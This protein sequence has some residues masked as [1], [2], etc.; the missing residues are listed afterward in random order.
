VKPALVSIVT[1][2]YNAAPWLAE[3]I[4]SVLAQTYQRWEYILLDNAS[5]DG[6]SEIARQF[7]AT[8]TRIRYVRNAELLN[9]VRNYNTALAMISPDSGYCKIVQADDWI[10]PDCV[11][12]M[13]DVFETSERVGLVGSYY[14]KD[15]AVR[16]YGLPYSRTPLP[17][18][19]VVRRL[20][21]DGLFLFGSPTAHMFRASIVRARQP[22]YAEHRY[23]EDTE[24]CVEILHEWDFGFVHQVLSFLRTGNESITSS[25]RSYG[26]KY[27][28]RYMTVRRY[29][30][31][32]F[33]PAQA[34]A[35][36]HDV[37]D[38]YYSFLAGCALRMRP[39]RLWRYHRKGLHMIGE[40]FDWAFL[41][42]RVVRKLSWWMVNPGLT[43]ANMFG[44]S[45][46]VDIPD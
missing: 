13:V 20:V 22:F 40:D 28:D 12:A 10:F 3:C 27:L 44:P 6:S 38:F 18:K 26:P 1:P 37:K 8:D 21:R 17:G 29:A 24:A 39:R 2:F 46:P 32:F 31:L 42:T 34:A 15:T 43:L 33:D 30:P 11:R 41:M 5:S 16:G 19:D 25:V 35:M 45:K 7:A 4:R 23:H 14:L 36:R 9:Q